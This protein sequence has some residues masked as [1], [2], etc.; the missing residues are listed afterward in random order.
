VTS[1]GWTLLLFDATGDV[2]RRMLLRFAARRAEP[3][4]SAMLDPT[5]GEQA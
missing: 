4:A 3:D 2:A 1:R 5:K